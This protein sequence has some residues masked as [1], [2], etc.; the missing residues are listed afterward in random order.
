MIKPELL[1]PAGDWPS[2]KAAID[3]GADAV[4]LGIKELNM[5][6]GGAKNFKLS[7]IKKIYELCKRNNV[8]LYVTLN[9][10]IFDDEIKKT[11]KIIKKIK[12]YVD[13]LIVWDLA[14]VSLCKKY[15]IDCFLSTQ[16][17]V[18]NNL[19]VKEHSKLGIKRITLARELN[20]KQ[21][22]NIK[23]PKEI[24]IHGALCYSISGRCFFSNEL[25]DKS[26]NRGECIQPCRRSY[27]LL[28]P[29]TRKE[30]KVENDKFL[31][32]RDLCT[33]PFLDKIVKTGACSLKIEGRGRSP[34]Y[35]KT[36]VS[37]Y[38][39]ALDAIFDKKFNKSLVENLMKELKKV[40]NKGFSSGFYL[41]LPT[42]DDIS[43][44]YGSEAIKR[45]IYVGKIINYYSNKKVMVVKVENDGLKI[46]EDIL[47]IGNTTG[48]VEM[49]INSMEID[50]KPINEIKRGLVGILA[51]KNVR[52][53]D[54]VYL[55]K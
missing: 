28:D 46:G 40:Y 26:A 54:K 34:E 19:A 11:E 41:G 35:V 17:S 23:F 18:A 20:L 53:G 38:R 36:V 43:K 37:V 16:A 6:T 2:L 12:S 13:A 47:I 52:K 10:I 39:R 4:Y 25:Y 3:S 8:K 7:E 9:T 45:K 24:F 29:E 21:I 33:L 44:Q 50:K 30:I 1:S 5:R 14:V 55:W 32:S 31:S 27:I 51:D 48:V 22:E 15:N 42:K 49:K